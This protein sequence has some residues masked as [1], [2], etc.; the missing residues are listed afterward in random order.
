[1]NSLEDYYTFLFH[2]SG[3]QVLLIVLRHIMRGLNSIHVEYSA[4]HQILV[5]C[6][7]LFRLPKY[8]KV[9]YSVVF[10]LVRQDQLSPIALVTYQ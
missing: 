5:E 4:V 8:L 6:F 7:D 1:M 3:K 10:A 9:C 2:P